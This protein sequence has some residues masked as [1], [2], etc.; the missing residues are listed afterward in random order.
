MKT[1]YLIA[2]LAALPG[3]ALA[4]TST[5][6]DTPP[7][8]GQW[9]HHGFDPDKELAHLTKKL[10]LSAT[11]Q[12]QIKPLLVTQAANLKTIHDNTS[13]SDEQ[14]H[15]QTKALFESTNQQI[16]SFLNPT[17][18]TQFQAMHQQHAPSPPQ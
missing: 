15:D 8:M 6:T 1:R 10:D 13:L 14:K 16:E 3:L 11:Q 7:P 18:V 4:Q 5:N 9:H 17:Q 2:I 12:G